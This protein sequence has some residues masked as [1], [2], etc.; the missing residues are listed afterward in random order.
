MKKEDIP[1]LNIFMMCDKL[2]NSA[3][4]KLPTDF[5]IRKCTPNDLKLW[6]EFPFD[7]EEEKNKYHDFMTNYFNDVYGSNVDE[8]YN[9]CLFVYDDLSNKPV[10]TCFIWKAYSR[11]N[12]I[13]WFKTLKEYEGKGL[14]RALLSYIM[15]SL[16]DED[17]PVYLHTQPGSFRAIGLYS[18]FGFKIVTNQK[19]GYRKND[20]KKCLPILKQFMKKEHF[21]NLKFIEAPNFFDESAKTSKINEF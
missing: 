16:N 7:N 6:K 14:G 1:D 19:I 11:I 15:K 4:S 21:D 8:F 20:Y 5:S 17:Y 3:I 2:N 13:H 9:R 10:A 12:T 18:D